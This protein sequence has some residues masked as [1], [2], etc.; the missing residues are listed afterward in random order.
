M[1]KL[2]W[3]KHMTHQVRNLNVGNFDIELQKKKNLFTSSTNTNLRS[4]SQ[5]T[6][7]ILKP[8]IKFYRKSLTYSGPKIWNQIPLHVR[9]CEHFKK[10]KSTYLSWWHSGG[11]LLLD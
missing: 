3:T 5:H 9:N 11:R 2:S 4:T 8:R 7:S 10:F 6:L 1:H